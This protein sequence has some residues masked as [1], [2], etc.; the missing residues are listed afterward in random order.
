MLNALEQYY[1][2]KPILYATEK[3][4]ALYLSGDYKEYDIWIRNVMAKPHLSDA[5]ECI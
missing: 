5:R 1:G 4:Y 2:V 3:S